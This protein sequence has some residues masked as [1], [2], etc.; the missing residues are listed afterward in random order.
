MGHDELDTADADQV[1]EFTYDY[2]ARRAIPPSDDDV[3]RVTFAVAQCA[4]RIVSRSNIESVL[5]AVT[6]AAD[7]E[8]P[9]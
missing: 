8:L 5:A 9:A 7:S 6:P 2:L 4:G 3:R 1:L